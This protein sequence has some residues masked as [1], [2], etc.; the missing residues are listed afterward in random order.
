MLVYE[1]NVGREM[2]SSVW[3][4][5][6][7]TRLLLFGKYSQFSGFMNGIVLENLV[8]V[9]S[10]K[11]FPAFSGTRKSITALITPVTAPNPGPT[12]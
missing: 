3:T 11:V 6:D 4:I 9:Q 7:H 1:Y 12:E 8:V 5:E 10:I 2:Q